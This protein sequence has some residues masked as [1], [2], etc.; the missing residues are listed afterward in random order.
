L[1]AFLAPPDRARRRAA[2]QLLFVNGRTIRDRTL[3]GAM[4]RAYAEVLPDALQPSYFLFLE[5]DPALVDVNV[6]PT[7][8]EVRFRDGSLVFR[9]VRH[10]A[11]EALQRADLAP[12]VAIAGGGPFTLPPP[13][14]VPPPYEGS[15]SFVREPTS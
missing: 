11:Q 13:R 8:A 14:T 7:K 4:R 5:I 12:R 9:L 15:A 2:T 1:T 10:A 3:A 6:H